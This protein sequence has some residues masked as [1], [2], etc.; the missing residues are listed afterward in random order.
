VRAS[1]SWR[2]PDWQAETEVE[3]RFLADQSGTNVDLAH[4]GWERLGP[5]AE[6]LARTWANGWPR[7]VACFARNAH[8]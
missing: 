8:G 5:D 3:V 6:T 1:R 7:V 2:S 4:R